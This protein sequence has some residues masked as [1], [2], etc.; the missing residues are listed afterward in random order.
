MELDSGKTIEIPKPVRQLQRRHIIHVYENFCKEQLYD[1]LSVSSLW[2]IMDNCNTSERKSMQGLDDYTADGLTGFDR[3]HSVVNGLKIDTKKKKLL[4]L[5]LVKAKHY[6]KGQYPVNVKSEETAIA[7]HCQIFALSDPDDPNFSLDCDHSHLHFACSECSNLQETLAEIK[8]MVPADD[9]DSLYEVV[10]GSE[11]FLEWQRHILRGVQQEL[12]K[13]ALLDKIGP[14]T[15]Y[16]L[17][18]WGMKYIPLRYRESTKDWFGKR[19]ISNHIDCVFLQDPE[20]STKIKKF[21]YYTIIDKVNQDGAAVLCT[22]QHV[23]QQIQQDFPHIKT[24]NDRSD[25]AACYSSA[26]VIL[27]KAKLAKELGFLLENTEFNEPQKGKD[28]CDR[29][30]AVIK[31]H[32][33][34]YWHSGHD[35]SD[36]AQMRMYYM[37]VEFVM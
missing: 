10:T 18:D 2:K 24:I 14:T 3:L 19:G 23:L 31:C 13:K 37:Q 20:D 34:S 16:W 21:T 22:N 28:Q 32:I 6:L 15:C 26:A 36:A 11:E 17:K 9:E 33:K 7:S 30:A 5:K 4:K 25:N 35:V 29:D 12:G 8:K 27:G 1:P